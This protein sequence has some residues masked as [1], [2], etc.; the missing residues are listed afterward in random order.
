MEAAVLFRQIS[1][2]TAEGQVLSNLGLLHQQSGEYQQ[3]ISYY[4]RANAI[5]RSRN[6]VANARVL[7]NLGACYQYLAEYELAANDFGQALREF[8]AHHSW[9]DAVR[10]KLNLGRTYVLEGNRALG[11]KTLNSALAE[12][13]MI[14]DRMAEAD[15]L[16]NLGQTF[17]GDGDASHAQSTLERALTLHRAL[18]DKRM[19][20]IDLHY[21]GESADALGDTASARDYL[22]QAFE[23]RRAIGLRDAASD[24]LFALARLEA[25]AGNPDTARELAGRA[26]IMLESVRNQ[27]PGPELRASFVG[28]KRRFFDLLINL[29]VAPGNPHNAEDSLLAAERGRGRALMDLLAEGR[30]LQGIPKELLDRRTNI[31][32]QIDLLAARLSAAPPGLATV[33]RR[34][35]ENLVSED[36]QIEASIHQSLSNQKLGQPLESVNELQTD[37]PSD[38]ALLEYYLAENESYLWLVQTTGVQLFRLPARAAIESQAAPVLQLFPEILDRKRSPDIDRRFQRALVRLS[39]TLIGPIETLRLP[40]RL[41]IVPDGVLT[42]IPFAAFELS[43]KRRLGLVHDLVVVPSAAYLGVGQKPRRVEEFPKVLLAFADPVYSRK[44]PR[45]AITRASAIANS[46]GPDLAR[47]PFNGEL[48]T[49]AALIPAGRR[50]FLTGF[51]AN[52]ESLKTSRLQ[53]YAVVHFSAHALIDDRIPELSRIA[54][55][56]V[57]SSG[58]VMNGFVRPYQLSQLHL[59][60]STVVLS[61]CDTALG[62]QV[63]GEGLAGFTTSLFSAGAS[64]LLLALSP[65]DAEASSEFLGETYRYVFGSARAPMDHAV[66]MA[67][68]A[69]ARSVRW[70][71]PYY[72]A[73][74]NLYG[75]PSETNLGP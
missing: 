49:A 40:G 50:Q 18:G 25:V 16:D 67:R 69:L 46:L 63:L 62:K 56:M 3:A 58:R 20:A 17:L 7:N 11:R 34:A 6:A 60:G 32:R 70:S 51:R 10:A 74:F 5:L 75:R 33:L 39:H 15:T 73:S 36:E 4:D 14:P 1:N 8:A 30:L 59:N 61:A 9:K 41:I 31:Q 2:R 28:R 55:S 38:S 43:G 23:I 47:L 12:A 13:T 21:L 29:E 65:I 57:G 19:E 26:L 54:L 52:V 71:D 35:G 42:R 45:V 37:L 72:W 53:D 22:N 27:V 24:S 48:D 66:T 44:D 68:R 64:Q